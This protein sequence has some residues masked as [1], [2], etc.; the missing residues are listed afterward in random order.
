MK[1]GAHIGRS[2][3]TVTGLR[4]TCMCNPGRL[5]AGVPRIF[6]LTKIQTI[7]VAQAYKIGTLPLV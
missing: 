6:F 5:P 2:V 7:S 3:G 4:G 1:M